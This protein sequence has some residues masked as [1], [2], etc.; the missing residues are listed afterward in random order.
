MHYLQSTSST[1]YAEMFVENP[2]YVWWINVELHVRNRS[3][4]EL[5]RNTKKWMARYD[6]RFSCR[7]LEAL[8]VDDGRTG[9]V[10]FLLAYPHLLECGQRGKDRSADPDG[11]LPLRRSNDLDLHGRRSECRDLF[12]HAVG[13]SGEHGGLSLIHIWRCR[14][15]ERCRSRWSPYH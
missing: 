3:N 4:Y 10:I 13:D 6:D 11:I 5:A 15:I 9:L 14:R 12:L 1:K 2:D 8:S 7:R